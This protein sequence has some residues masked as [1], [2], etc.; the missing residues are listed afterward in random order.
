[1]RKISMIVLEEQSEML[2]APAGGISAPSA[3]TYVNDFR[4]RF[5][6]GAQGA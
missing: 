1:V 5:C 2:S 4:W 3:V 6:V